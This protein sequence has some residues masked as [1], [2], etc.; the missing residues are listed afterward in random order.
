MSTLTFFPWLRLPDDLTVAGYTLL[1]YRRGRLPCARDHARQEVVDSILEPYW[2]SRGVPVPEATLLQVGGRE[3]T[4][5]LPLE[6]IPKLL[7]FG[8]LVAFSALAAREYFNHWYWNRDN[9]QLIIQNFDNPKAGVYIETRRRHGG[10]GH[11]MSQDYFVVSRPINISGDEVELDVPLLEALF[12]ADGNGVWP[13]I[14]EAIE[15]FNLASSEAST[16]SEWTEL[17]LMNGA[18]ERLFESPGREDVL[19]AGLTGSLEPEEPLPVERFKK[20]ANNPEA[21][22]RFK[23]ADSIR[24]VWIRD[25]FRVRNEYAHG[26]VTTRYPALWSVREH[27]LLASF[28]FPLAIKKVLDANGVYTLSDQDQ[29]HINAFEALASE[30]H[31]RSGQER[32]R[33]LRIINSVERKRSLREFIRDL[34]GNGHT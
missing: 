9:L 24:E 14:R 12:A 20:F 17:L 26:V 30:D 27:L 33:W 2:E 13:R 3:L 21:A 22:S 29:L 28:S 25:F 11:A 16:T 5:H 31:L 7:E 34:R 6:E 10:I 32:P 19:A 4:D 8:S 1:R 23:R 18:F 15:I